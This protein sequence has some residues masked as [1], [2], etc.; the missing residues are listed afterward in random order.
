MSFFEELKRWKV[1]RVALVY[2]ATAFVVLQAADLVLPRL[3]VPEWAMSLVVVL[4][5]LGFP[6]ALW[7][8]W[9]FDVTPD[10]VVRTE[11]QRQ[12]SAGHQPSRRRRSR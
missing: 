3:G 12:G 2:A 6:L 5:L 4:A 11:P 9:A 1:I 8:A 10:G 7:L